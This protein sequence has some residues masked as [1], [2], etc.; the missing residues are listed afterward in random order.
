[1]TTAPMDTV[2]RPAEDRFGR[3]R[4]GH[5]DR[6]KGRREVGALAAHRRTVMGLGLGVLLIVAGAVLAFAV[7]TSVSGVD[8]QLIGWILM[9]AGVLVIVL[10]LVI[11]MPRSRRARSTAVTTDPYGRQSVTERDDRITGI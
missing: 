6:D 4:L 10:S 1:M 8:L 7:D 9:G 3:H 5:V 2:G 11:F